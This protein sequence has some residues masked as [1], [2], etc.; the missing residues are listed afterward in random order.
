MLL[1]LYICERVSMWDAEIYTSLILNELEWHVCISNLITYTLKIK[2]EIKPAT[3][4]QGI[5]WMA[6]LQNRPQ[7]NQPL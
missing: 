6:L 7:E 3:Q 4:R 2:T 5:Q 1:N